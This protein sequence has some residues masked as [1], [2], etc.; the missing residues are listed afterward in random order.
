MIRL[1]FILF[2]PGTLLQKLNYKFVRKIHTAL[3]NVKF[4]AELFRLFF[5]SY[6][7]YL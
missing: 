5:V 4:V 6:Q 3:V 1:D 7:P 2:V